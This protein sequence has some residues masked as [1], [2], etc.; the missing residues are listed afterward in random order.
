MSAKISKVKLTTYSSYKKDLEKDAA[1]VPKDFSDLLPTY[2]F[3]ANA[4]TALYGHNNGT[5]LAGRAI[6]AA[7][8]SGLATTMFEIYITNKNWTIQTI[9]IDATPKSPPLKDINMLTLNRCRKDLRAIVF[10]YWAEFIEEADLD[11]PGKK[12]LSEEDPIFATQRPDFIG[13]LHSKPEF[14]H[15]DAL[16]YRVRTPYGIISMA[17]VFSLNSIC[18]IATSFGQSA[19]GAI[20]PTL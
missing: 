3:P 5:G 2:R 17:S 8:D 19:E 16:T 20:L 6:K 18:E 7:K 10:D 15:L 11:D 1:R 12:M 13:F 14:N 4:L 9:G